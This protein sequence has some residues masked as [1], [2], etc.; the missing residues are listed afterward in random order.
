MFRTVTPIISIILGILLFVFF[1]HP[2][3]DE[4]KKTQQDRDDYR[5]AFN[6]HQEFNTKLESLIA[7]KAAISDSERNRLDEFIPNE[8]DNSGLIV[9]IEKLARTNGMLFG[10]IKS[11]AEA[12]KKL[13][14]SDNSESTGADSATAL[15]SSDI[16]FDVIGTYSQFR[17]FL[18]SLE[19]SLTLFEITK[20]SLTANEGDTQFQQYSLTVRVY[21]S[22]L[23][24]K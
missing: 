14:P 15:V 21:A 6:D 18:K 7:Q 17:N 2:A 10:N 20:I 22:S 5:K 4:A 24:T 19:S 13:S 16:S 3:Y 11:D 23:K 12:A 1:T 9:K 8:I